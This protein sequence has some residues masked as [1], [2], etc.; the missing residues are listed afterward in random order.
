MRIS[1]KDVCFVLTDFLLFN[2][3]FMYMKSISLRSVLVTYYIGSGDQ[4]SRFNTILIVL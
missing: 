1:I 3:V 2:Y 4:V